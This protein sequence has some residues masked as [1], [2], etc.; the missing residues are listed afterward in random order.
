MIKL[1]MFSRPTL[2]GRMV[3]ILQYEISLGRWGQGH[4]ALIS[5][6]TLGQHPPPSQS[7]KNFID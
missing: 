6:S 7:L 4:T 5:G 2:V 3:F 1:Y